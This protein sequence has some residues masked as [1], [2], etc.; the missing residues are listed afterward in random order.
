[1][2]VP[3]GNRKVGRENGNKQSPLAQHCGRPLL[4]EEPK[5]IS[6]S[7]MFGFTDFGD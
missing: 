5:G 6:K 4:D 2:F 3:H 7:D 1:M